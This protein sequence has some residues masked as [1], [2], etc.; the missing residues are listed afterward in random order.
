MRNP[1]CRE[2]GE[3][4]GEGPRAE[5]RRSKERRTG[6]N[7]E[8]GLPDASKRPTRLVRDG[9]ARVNPRSVG[10]DE[11]SPARRRAKQDVEGVRNPEDGTCRRLESPGLTGA[12]RFKR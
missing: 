1:D 8:A 12:L 2:R 6:E 4:P 10:R 9:G 11:T 3:S 7:A 5:L